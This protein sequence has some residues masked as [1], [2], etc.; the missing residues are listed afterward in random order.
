[1]FVSTITH[2]PIC[3]TGLIEDHDDNLFVQSDDYRKEVQ[4]I[5]TPS[6]QEDAPNTAQIFIL[7]YN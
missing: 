3:E 4:D 7:G 2:M 5:L 6:E 1:M